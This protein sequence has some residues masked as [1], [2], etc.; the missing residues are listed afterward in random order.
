MHSRKI[1]PESA[2]P[3]RADDYSRNYVCEQRR[4]VQQARE[5]IEGGC[6]EKNHPQIHDKCYAFKCHKTTLFSWRRG[7]ILLCE[8]SA[9]ENRFG[10]E[11]EKDEEYKHANEDYALAL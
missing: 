5:K 4:L 7:Y 9:R 2:E 6:G 11:L 1:H 8:G 10:G 3:E